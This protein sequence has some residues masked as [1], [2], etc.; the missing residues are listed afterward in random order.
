MAVTT[1]I[2]LASWVLAIGGV[3]EI[4]IVTTDSSAVPPPVMVRR[5]IRTVILFT[6][7][8]TPHVGATKIGRLANRTFNGVI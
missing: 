2:P 4:Q 6:E 5:N 1:E 8:I 7:F 3:G